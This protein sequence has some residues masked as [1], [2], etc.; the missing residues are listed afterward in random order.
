MKKPSHQKKKK[1]ILWK[2]KKD[3]QQIV[4]KDIQ[5]TKPTKT[6]SHICTSKIEQTLGPPRLLIIT[7]SEICQMKKSLLSD[8]TLKNYKKG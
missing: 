2:R 5:I 7:I 8:T 6:K 3:F 1:R 4:K